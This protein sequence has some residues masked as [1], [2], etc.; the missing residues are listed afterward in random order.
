MKM[1]IEITRILPRSE[2]TP[3]KLLLSVW[4]LDL[5]YDVVDATRGLDSDALFVVNEI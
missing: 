5:I 4:F 2:I 3:A 1:K